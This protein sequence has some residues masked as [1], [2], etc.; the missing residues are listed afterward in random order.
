[1]GELAMS[2]LSLSRN[3]AFDPN[4]VRRIDEHH[5]CELFFHQNI[6]RD[7]GGCVPTMKAMAAELPNVAQLANR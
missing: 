3:V 2:N 7:L 6:E 5:L 1:L 4:I